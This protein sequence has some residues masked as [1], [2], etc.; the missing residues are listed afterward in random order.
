MRFRHLGGG[1]GDGASGKNV[2][3][4]VLEDRVREHWL[5]AECIVVGDRRP[6]IAALVTLDDA[7]FARWKQRQGKPAGATIADL[8]NDPELR[9]VVQQAVDRANTAVSRAEGIKRFRILPGRFEVGAELTPT[10]KVRRNFVLAT[11]ASDIEA[12]Y[13]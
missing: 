8:R 1:G 3:P 2:V 10:Q 4:S 9:P 12:L 7:A 6:Y 13:A 11:H 5:I